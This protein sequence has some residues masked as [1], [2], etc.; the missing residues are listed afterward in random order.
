MQRPLV[1]AYHL[2]WTGYGHWLPNDPRGSGSKIV[3]NPALEGLGPVHLGRKQ[4]QPRRPVVR[5]FYQEAAPRL[6]HPLIAFTDEQIDVIAA[7]FAQVIERQRYTCYA[8]AILRD[9]AHLV[10]RKHRDTA[11]EML[12]QLQQQSRATLLAIGACPVDHPVWI[13]GG[14][15]GF[16]DS[17]HEVRTRVRYTLRNPK[18]DGLAEQ[19]W[20]FV[21]PYDNWP[22]HPGHNPNSPWARRL[23]DWESRSQATDE[24]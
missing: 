5:E 8:C 24:G 12:E 13:E 3:R 2:V 7:A 6:R 16:L 21:V 23:R 1:I 19:T 18:K 14:W 11:E 20:P 4:I 10:I 22:L 17:P 15:R 9:H